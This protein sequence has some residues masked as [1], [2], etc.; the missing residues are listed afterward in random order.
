MTLNCDHKSETCLCTA[1]L[2]QDKLRR[3]AYALQRLDMRNCAHD[4]KLALF[5]ADKIDKPPRDIPL[6]QATLD[7]AEYLIEDMINHIEETEG[8]SN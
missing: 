2:P 5:I 6:S 1:R 3:L 7:M 8:W 4:I